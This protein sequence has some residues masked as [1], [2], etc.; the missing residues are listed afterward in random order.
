M[1]VV[2]HNAKDVGGCIS[3][4]PSK[5]MAHRYFICSALSNDTTTIKC[6]SSSNDIK[7]IG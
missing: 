6:S 1:D 4:I 5:S 7:D 3:A 2:I